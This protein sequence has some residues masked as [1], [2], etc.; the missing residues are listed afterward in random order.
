MSR[1]STA[2]SHSSFKRACL[3]CPLRKAKKV[4]S[5]RSKLSTLLMP[6]SKAMLGEKKLE[7]YS[8]QWAQQVTISPLTQTPLCKHFFLS[9]WASKIYRL[10]NCTDNPVLTCILLYLY[11]TLPCWLQSKLSTDMT[12]CPPLW[13]HWVNPKSNW[14]LKAW[15]L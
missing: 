1:N 9:T 13:N 15:I 3:L 5:S 14:T 8:Y 2:P 7:E 11:T 10:V 4:Y 12:K 6:N